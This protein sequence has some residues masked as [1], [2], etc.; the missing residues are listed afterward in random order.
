MSLHFLT[1]NMVITSWR[2]LSCGQPSSV[3]LD[4]PF[5]STTLLNTAHIA[6]MKSILPPSCNLRNDSYYASLP[7][8]FAWSR[9]L[10]FPLKTHLFSL[11]NLPPPVCVSRTKMLGW[12]Y[13]Q[14]FPQSLYNAAFLGE[15]MQMKSCRLINRS[16]RRSVV[17]PYPIN[18]Q[19]L[20]LFHHGG[21]TPFKGA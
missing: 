10:S 3:G 21:N 5:H 19:L 15:A 7:L 8:K 20:V 18:G 6:W 13:A 2:S 4:I 11:A 12:D 14:E 16:L 9:N 17:L 1:G